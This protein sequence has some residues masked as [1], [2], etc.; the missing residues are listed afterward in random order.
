MATY[1]VTL[2]NE[3]SGFQQTIDISDT[4][5]IL[6]RAYEQGIKIPF[7]CVIGACATCEGKLLSGEVD[8]SEQI[9]LSENQIAEGCVLTCVAKPMSDCTVAIEI[10]SYL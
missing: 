7:E 3:S 6:D 9:F 1:K 4:Q 8:Q 5:S 2:V 10:G